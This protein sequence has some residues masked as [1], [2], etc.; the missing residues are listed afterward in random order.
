MSF[1]GFPDAAFVSYE[2]LSADNRKA[3]WTDHRATYEECVKAPMLSPLAV[4]GRAATR[5]RRSARV[6]SRSPGYPAAPPA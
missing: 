2:G 5:D 3:Y 6:A 4:T 1:E